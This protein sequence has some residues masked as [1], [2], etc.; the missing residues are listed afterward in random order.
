[1]KKLHLFIIK[2]YLGPFFLTFFISLFLLLMQFLWKYIDELVGKDLD[3]NIILE[4]MF[5]ASAGLVPMALPLAILLASIMTLGN[6]G[7][8]YELIALKSS[9]I[10]L[11]RLM[12][13]LIIFVTILSI[14]AFFY[15]NN[16][17]PFTK[18]KMSALLWDI[19]H[20]RPELSIKAGI[21]S[22]EIDGFS[23]KIDKK[24][25]KTG[26]LYGILIYDHTKRNGNK[27]VTV[28]DSGLMNLTKDGSAMVLTLFS[29]V[30]YTEEK[31]KKSNREKR[32]F[33]HRKDKF[34]EEKIFFK[35]KGVGFE[36]TDENLFSQN[37]QMLTL[38]Q[39]IKAEDSLSKVLDKRREKVKENLLKNNYFRRNI[40][41]LKKFRNMKNN[42][43]KEENNFLDTIQ[44]NETKE[45]TYFNFVDFYNN[46][47]KKTHDKVMKVALNYARSTKSYITNSKEDL[48]Y[49]KKIIRKHKSQ[50]HLKFTLSFACFVFFFIGAPLGAII[51]KGGLGMP[52]VVSILFFVVYYMLSIS[53]KKLALEEV[54]ETY[55]GMWL[56]SAILFPVGIFLTYKA[57]TDSVIL[58]I[59]IYLDFFKKFKKKLKK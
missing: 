50:W 12:F 33:P 40:G 5:Y 59:E 46:L 18:L 7:E 1:M 11:F 14:S 21:F 51:R 37:Y 8:N 16:M 39:L 4:L 58:D 25:K 36:R 57:A 3:I 9:G 55:Q 15:S 27:N 19:Q 48:F 52:V 53:G 13:P 34:D 44:K 17:L 22:N 2:S 32:T 30:N 47:D 31:D 35:L 24:D 43:K 49:R 6:L 20:Q 10:S 45:K 56:S 29:G 54:L 38:L 23:I 41:K 28:A 42:V 26:K